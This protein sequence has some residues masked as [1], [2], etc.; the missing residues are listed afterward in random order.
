MKRPSIT[1]RSDVTATLLALT[2]LG[3]TEAS[4][5]AEPSAVTPTPVAVPL[6]TDSIADAVTLPF[7]KKQGSHLVKFNLEDANLADLVKHMS[8]LTGR[9]FVYGAK[10][11]NVQATVVTPEPV[12]LEEAYRAFLSILEANGM[13]VVQQGAFLKIVDT[14]GISGVPTPLLGRGANVPD[15]ERY[16]TR[17]HRLTHVTPA[18]V[19][20]ILTKFKS[21][22]GDI[23]SYDAGRLLIIT[24]TGSQVRRLLRLLEEV[25]VAGESQHLWVEPVHHGSAEALAKQLNELFDA[26]AGAAAGKDAPAENGRLS[27]LVRIVADES[28]GRLLIVATDDAYQRVLAVVKR[29]DVKEGEEARVHVLPLQHGSAEELQKTLSTLINAPSGGGANAAQTRAPIF[30]GEVRISADKSVN[31]L[32]ISASNR[33][34]ATLRLVIDKLDHARRQVFIEAVVMDLAVSDQTAFGTAFHSA[35]T[36][37]GSLLVG[38]FRSATSIAFPSTSDTSLLQGLAAGVRGPGL[39][40][41]ESLTGTGLSIPAFGVVIDAIASSGKSNV[42]ATPHV[43][44][45]DNV[46]AE[47][48]VGENIPLQ[49]NVNSSALSSLASSSNANTASLLSSLSGGVSPQRQDVGTKVKVTP[50]INESNQ[51]RLEIEQESSS[52]G[53]AVGTLGVVPIQKRTATTTV[54]AEDQQTI[55]LGGLMRDEYVTSREKIPVLGDIPLLGALFSHNTTTRRKSNLLLILTPHVIREQ[56][57]LRRIFERKMQERQEFLD[58]HFVFSGED[59]TPPRDWSRTNGLL[60]DIRQAY[61]ERDRDAE[62]RAASERKEPPAHVPS[63]PIDEKPSPPDANPES[64]APGSTQSATAGAATTTPS[65]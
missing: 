18:Q 9:R 59:W 14:G 63:A 21:K 56:A 20:P 22:D 61:K 42:L 62:L 1:R 10:L 65:D 43:I 36:A 38:G 30:E 23:S 12:T 39:T 49:Q 37:N 47:L 64:P 50:H 58:R 6:T 8:D 28:S 16:V 15:A 57:D 52:A 55:V 45:T 51:V 17:L 26:N 19:V 35:A 5:A 25:D 7:K 13:T 11:R 4:H 34:F 46:P 44:A 29:L 53:A 27:G 24:D 48:S 40:G 54:V 33:D 32:L 2:W 60:E 41:T 31:S 3:S